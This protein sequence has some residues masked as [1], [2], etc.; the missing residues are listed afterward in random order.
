M[1]VLSRPSGVIRGYCLWTRRHPEGPSSRDGSSAGWQKCGQRVR[2][3]LHWNTTRE[4]LHPAD[5]GLRMTS[6]KVTV[7]S[8]AA[9]GGAVDAS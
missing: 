1:F 7:K 9:I 6:F 2:T 4:I 8:W 5:A 3:R